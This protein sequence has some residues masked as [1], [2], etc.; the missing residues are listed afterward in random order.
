MACPARCEW[1]PGRLDQA[2]YPGA[3]VSGADASAAKGEKLI[4]SARVRTTNAQT[5]IGADYAPQYVGVV[6]EAMKKDT[7]L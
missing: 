4:W 3:V 7:P 5:T 6:V 1:R 2:F